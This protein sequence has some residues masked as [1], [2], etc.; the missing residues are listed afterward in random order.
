MEYILLMTSVLLGTGKNMVSKYTGDKFSGLANLFK[1]NIVTALI[2]I[3][4]F[5]FKGVNLEIFKNPIAFTLA[6]FYGIFTMISQML[7][8]KAVEYSSTA[9]CS[10][11]YSMG[12]V[13][14]TLFSIIALG[15]PFGAFK[16]IGFILILISFLLVGNLKGGNTN[17]LYFAF[18]AMLSSGI[19]GIIQK[20]IARV[21]Q[22]FE[23][24]EYLT[25]AFGVMLAGSVIG[26][27]SV[28]ERTKGYKPDFFATAGIMGICVA[29]ANSINTSLAGKMAGIV[30][31]TCVNG[32]TI[33]F[34]SIAS[35][36]LFKE[37]LSKIQLIGILL[38]VLAIVMIVL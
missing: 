3:M 1:T 2:A 14:P 26:I 38:G 34:S 33:I 8:I 9:V 13:L 28:K 31:F 4:V 12:F 17:K 22:K 25:L 20:L 19:I 18:L 7:F 36:I 24:S 21:P 29:F 30:F 11:I 23:T 5:G 35:R 37:K 16:L 15:E 27:F 32:G 6:V 10:L